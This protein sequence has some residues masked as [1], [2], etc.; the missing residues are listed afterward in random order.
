MARR[1]EARKQQ[2]LLQHKLVPSSQ[3]YSNQAPIVMGNQ[4]AGYTLLQ[5]HEP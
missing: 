5:G 4:V 2:Q 3:V 1:P